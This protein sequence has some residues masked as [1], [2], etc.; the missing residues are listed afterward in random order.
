MKVDNIHYNLNRILSYNKPFNFVISA[1][2]AGK[3]TSTWLYNYKQFVK[4]KSTTLVIR[5]LINDI[6]ET[7]IQD[8]ENL[9]NKFNEEQPIKLVFKKGSIKEGIVDV[10]IDGDIFFRVIALSNPLSRIKSLMLPRLSTIIFDEFICNTRLGEKYLQNEVFK[11]KELFNTFQREAEKLRV[12][13][14]G[15]PYS[16]YNPYF[17]WV[18]VKTASLYP[19]SFVTGDTWCIEVYELTKELKEYILKKN[20][21]YQFDDSYAKYAFDGRAI[22]DEFVQVV[23]KQ[24]EGFQ[25]RYVFYIDGKKLGIFKNCNNDAETNPDYYFFWVGI[26]NEYTSSRRDIAC[27]DYNDLIAGNYL[28]SNDDKKAFMFLKTCFRFR[29]IKFKTIE[30]SYLFEQ[31]YNNI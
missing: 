28:I 16:L 25:L 27:F 2:E 11:F 14:L 13:F 8:I 30:E 7:Y 3:S 1:R 9:I 17:S 24:P 10:Y 5:R 15:N 22:N 21:L 23:E 12:I 6:T 26:I 4:K 20:P 18:G 31:V 19:G 29:S